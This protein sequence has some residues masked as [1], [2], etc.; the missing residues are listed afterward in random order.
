MWPQERERLSIASDS[1]TKLRLRQQELVSK[2]AAAK[3]TLDRWRPKLLGMLGASELP[4]VANIKAEAD[5]VLAN[6]RWVISSVRHCTGKKETEERENWKAA[7]E[8]RKEGERKGG[9]QE[10]KG[11]EGL[12]RRDKGTH[13]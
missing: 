10:R 6:K 8:A 5:A 4:A 9:V 2:E 12:K 3:A 7:K 1:A 11:K 13:S